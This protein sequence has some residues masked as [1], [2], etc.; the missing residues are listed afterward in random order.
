MKKR[1]L[2]R[3]IRIFHPLAG[4]SMCLPS[5]MIKVLFQRKV[6]PETFTLYLFKCKAWRIWI[7]TEKSCSSCIY[8]KVVLVESTFPAQVLSSPSVTIQ[9]N[10]Y[11]KLFLSP[12]EFVIPFEN[13]FIPLR[14]EYTYPN[15]PV[16]SSWILYLPPTLFVKSSGVAL[17]CPQM[18]ST[19]LGLSWFNANSSLKYQMYPTS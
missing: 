7:M 12:F 5:M 19:A 11:C 8:L 13:V 2:C 3:N 6:L 18:P 16:S 1:F 14:G 17:L 9:H 10:L 4:H 15:I